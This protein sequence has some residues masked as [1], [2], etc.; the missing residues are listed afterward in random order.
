K[1]AI[2]DED[3]WTDRNFGNSTLGSDV[4]DGEDTSDDC[5]SDLDSDSDGNAPRRGGGNNEE[6]CRP[7]TAD[8]ARQLQR[9]WIKKYDPGR[10]S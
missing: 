9:E 1:P 4:D 7:L 5:V 6:E 2:M 8:E 10:H 3:E